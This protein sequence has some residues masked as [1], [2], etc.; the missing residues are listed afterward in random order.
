MRSE[1]VLLSP[2]GGRSGCP[3]GY[4][5]K[6]TYGSS[7]KCAARQKL[8]CC[9][10]ILLYEGIIRTCIFV[11]TP[12][13]SS[14]APKRLPKWNGSGSVLRSQK[15][16]P[17]GAVGVAAAA[18]HVIRATIRRVAELKATVR[19]GRDKICIVSS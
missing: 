6:P 13:V 15:R 8:V 12:A 5:R 18:G 16:T 19:G 10:S 1:P 3:N 7:I 14:A 9:I 4:S 2:T 17:R 11:T